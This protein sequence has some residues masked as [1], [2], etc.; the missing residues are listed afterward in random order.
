MILIVNYNSKSGEFGKC[1]IYDKC[2]KYLCIISILL[3][4]FGIFYDVLD[5]KIVFLFK[6][7]M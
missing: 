2:G 7:Y 4:F 6:K 1:V 5:I 3:F